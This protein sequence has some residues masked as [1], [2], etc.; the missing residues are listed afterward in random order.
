MAEKY[1]SKRDHNAME[2][3]V[4]RLIAFKTVQRMRFY[5]DEEAVIREK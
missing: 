2:I 4:P 5:K 1:L 3:A